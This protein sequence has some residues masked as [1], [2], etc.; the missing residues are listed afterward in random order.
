VT[1]AWREM[2]DSGMYAN[3]PGFL[4]A[5]SGTRQNTNIFRVPPG[6]GAQI[7]T[8]GMPI[9]QAVM[10]LPYNTTGM[11]A[12]MQLVD[13]MVQTGQRVGGT[14]EMQVGE[15]RGD[16][17]VGTTLALIDQAVKIIN[18]VHKRLHA[19]QAEEFQLLVKVFREHPESF[20]QR[21]CKSKTM[22]DVQKFMQAADNCELVPQADPNTAS[23]G[24][25]VM[26]IT[27]LKQL[28]QASPNLYDPIA[29]DTAALQ[30]MGWSNP[31]QFF[32]PPAA[33]AAPPPQLQ[34]LQAKMANEKASTQAKMVEAH[35]RDTESKA[36]AAETQAKMQQGAFAPKQDAGSAGQQ[37]QVDTPVD[38][39]LA[40]AKLMDANTKAMEVGLKAKMAHTENQ[41][42]DQDREA[43]R[44][45]SMLNLAKEVI[46]EPK[47]AAG[48]GK[49]A[50]KIAKQ[51]DK[52]IK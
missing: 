51:V 37:Q 22:W 32:V 17:P 19:S 47:D 13:N 15:G 31:E 33:R 27:G 28:Q 23:M 3:F 26:K 14:S 5:K 49:K 40:H 45:E 24:Q 1:A 16:A 43:K 25:R 12:L 41:N 11:P 8:N 36:K 44:Q 2:L 39:A 38:Q 30:A 6:G 52:G 20:W 46:M 34:E 7:D 18:S 35:A 48:A 42:R 9:S 4:V 50:L 21:K 10:P 29:I